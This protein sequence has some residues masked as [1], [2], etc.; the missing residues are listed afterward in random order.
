MTYKAPAS[1][2]KAAVTKRKCEAKQRPSAEAGRWI[3]GRRKLAGGLASGRIRQH[4][5]GSRDGDANAQIPVEMIFAA[6]RAISLASI[7]VAKAGE[8]IAAA[9][10]VT[11]SS[12]GSGLDRDQRHRF[13]SDNRKSMARRRNTRKARCHRSDRKCSGAEIDEKTA[14]Y[15]STS[16]IFF[17]CARRN[18]EPRFS[19]SSI[20]W[21]S[22]MERNTS[23]ILGSNCV[24][25]QRRISSRA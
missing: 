19:R 6:S 14:T 24:P 23:T 15:C 22:G 5:G 13:P 2:Q 1:D 17:K 3:G 7:L 9:N 10:A 20:Q 16:P 18:G 8:F 4:F 25:A 12:F 11:V 21:F